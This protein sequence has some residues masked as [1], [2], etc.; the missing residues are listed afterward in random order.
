LTTIAVWVEL[1]EDT[2][3]I[4]G[5]S[6]DDPE[7]DV[8]EPAGYIK[9]ELIQAVYIWQPLGGDATKCH[10]QQVT[11]VDPKGAVPAM[12]VNSFLANRAKIFTGFRE[13]C[14]NEA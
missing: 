8:E 14:H 9:A 10:L 2:Y 4:C 11:L 1:G 5:C 12:I 7:P 6:I 13:M 3:A